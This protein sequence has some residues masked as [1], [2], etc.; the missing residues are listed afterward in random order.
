MKIQSGAFDY[1]QSA[2]SVLGLWVKILR[3]LRLVISYSV[4]DDYGMLVDV[5]VGT[6]NVQQHST[7]N[8]VLDRVI[9]SVLTYGFRG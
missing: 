6:H 1:W 4:T 2:Y 7:N 3:E 9:I 5:K 8:L